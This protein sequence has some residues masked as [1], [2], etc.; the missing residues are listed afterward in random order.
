MRLKLSKHFYGSTSLGQFLGSSTAFSSKSMAI[1]TDFTDHP[2]QT[3]MRCSNFFKRLIWRRSPSLL[4][5]KFLKFSNR[6]DFVFIESII[7]SILMSTCISWLTK[8]TC[9]I[10]RGNRIVTVFQEWLQSIH[11]SRV[12]RLL[13]TLSWSRSYDSIDFYSINEGRFV[14]QTLR[15]QQLIF[16]YFSF[17]MPAADIL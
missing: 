4:H 10:G 17:Q 9:N 7:E 2:E 12:F 1:T 14:N 3:F 15:R 6:V 11:G 5:A 13:F 8:V 16:R